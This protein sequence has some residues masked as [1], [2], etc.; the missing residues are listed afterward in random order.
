MAEIVKRGIPSSQ[1]VIT[2]ISCANCY[3]PDADT[4]VLMRLPDCD[5]RVWLGYWNG[6]HW[7]TVDGM[8][9]GRVSHWADVPAGPE[10]PHAA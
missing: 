10:V 5:E 1:E 4:T 3:L 7:L 2:W 9:A 8:K 6:D